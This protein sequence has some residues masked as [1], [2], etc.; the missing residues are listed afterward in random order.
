MNDLQRISQDNCEAIIPNN[1]DYLSGIPLYFTS[2][3]KNQR[4]AAPSIDD[5]IIN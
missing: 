2:Q 3:I 5:D 1:Y 4:V